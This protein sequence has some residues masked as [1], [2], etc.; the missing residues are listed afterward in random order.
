MNGLAKNLSE[1]LATDASTRKSQSVDQ[2]LF[3]TPHSR[4]KQEVI[5]HLQSLLQ[6]NLPLSVR[7]TPALENFKD[8]I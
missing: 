2:L 7:T 3:V 4:Q 5:E 8:P 6:N 1:L